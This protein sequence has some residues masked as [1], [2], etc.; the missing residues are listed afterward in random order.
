M[1]NFPKLA[2]RLF[3]LSCFMGLGYMTVNQVA[4]YIKNEDTSITSFKKLTS[5]NYPT[6]TLCFEDN[7]ESQGFSRSIYR[8]T[9]M[10]NDE[11]ITAYFD[12]R[13]LRYETSPRIQQD[14]IGKWHPNISLIELKSLV[15]IPGSM[16]IP[17]PCTGSM[18]I[19]NETFLIP[20]DRY[21]SL[22]KGL[23]TRYLTLHRQLD[24][25]VSSEF[26]EVNVTFPPEIVRDIDFGKSTIN[27]QDILEKYT[28]ETTNETTYG[29][30]DAEYEALHTNCFKGPMECMKE[31]ERRVEFHAIEK[32]TFPFVLSHQDPDRVCYTPRTKH[33]DSNGHHNLILDIEALLKRL[34]PLYSHLRIYI[35]MQG[36]LLRMFGSDVTHFRIMDMMTE[37]CGDV[38]GG[39]INPLCSGRKVSFLVSQ[40]TMLR[41]R[42][43]AKLPC[44]KDL[45]NE[46]FKIID[47]IIKMVGCVPSF[48]KDIYGYPGN[49]P[50]CGTATEYAKIYRFA[51]NMTLSRSL[52]VQ[53]C[54]EM[55]VVTNILRG[56]G[57]RQERK[58]V[59]EKEHKIITY[60]DISFMVG[61]N[62]FQEIIY[63]RDFGAESC[64]S[65]VGGFVGIFVGSSLLQL[66]EILAS[67]WN[68]LT[69]ASN[70]F[71]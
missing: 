51:S 49:T 8:T 54:N 2:R 31:Y 57:K 12:G 65:G 14:W 21:K 41:K 9:K 35:H 66:P 28:R 43:D 29:W 7:D 42:H 68:C 60:L 20:P 47:A 50:N 24:A 55:I 38:G 15:G 45:Q 39:T 13:W 23:R 52:I 71:F 53:P 62:I 4:R 61:S 58:I 33:S 18:I 37:Q 64:W 26:D 10:C 19:F 48:W 22:L 34:H 3:S 1:N 56:K 27:F 46:D 44:N 17:I 36:Q 32:E 63:T 59:N 6:Y 70:K 30:I 69:K 11:N 5:D 16:Y 40:V 25:G 67:F